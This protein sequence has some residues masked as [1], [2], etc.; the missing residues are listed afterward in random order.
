MPD[1]YIKYKLSTKSA[2]HYEYKYN[3]KEKIINTK[4]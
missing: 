1:E 4:Q 3:Y 2:Q